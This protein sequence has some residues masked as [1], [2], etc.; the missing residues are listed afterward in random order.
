MGNPLWAPWR[1][2]YILAP[3]DRRRACIFC[4][5]PAA[6]TSERAERHVVCTTEHAF[7]MMNRYPF[8]AGHLLIVPYAHHQDL[9]QLDP[10]VH[11]AL[12]RL[13]RESAARL[14]RAVSAEGLNVGL[15]LGAVAGAG[16]AEHL[17]VHIVPRWPGDTNFMPVLADARVVP[18]ALE[19]TRRHLVPYFADL[20]AEPR[21]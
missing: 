6:S 21:P 8:A 5:V 9:D 18:Q 11:D 1:M 16:V 3:K 2:E 19:D 20:S 14:R 17:H 4:D 7:V 10:L 15:N 13:V 12:F